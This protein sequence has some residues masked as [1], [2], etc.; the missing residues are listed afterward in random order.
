MKEE[1]IILR[2]YLMG[3][4][5]CFSFAGGGLAMLMLQYV[6]GGKWGLLLRRP[7]EA[8]SRTIWLVGADVRADYL[9]VEAPLSVGGVSD[10][11]SGRRG[12]VESRW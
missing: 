9:S 11:R 6:S 3:Y 2:A 1:T 8:M 4:M 7:L 5:I 10:C 12:A